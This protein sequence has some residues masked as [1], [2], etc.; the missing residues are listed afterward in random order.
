[1]RGLRSLSTPAKYCAAVAAVIAAS[2]IRWGLDPV[3]GNRY[4]YLLQYITVLLAAR[5]L[6]FGPS[7]VSLVVATLP[8]LYLIAGSSHPERLASPGFWASL[9]AAYAFT[10]F[11]IWLIDRQTRMGA[12][13]ESSTPLADPRLEELKQ[14]VTHREREERLSAQFRAIV[15][16][17]DDAV[18]SKDLSGII[19][20]WNFGAEEIFG[21]TAD[22]MI[23]RPI[24]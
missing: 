15:E 3:L 24:S 20:S 13:V 2:L 7:F 16:S 22:E 4:R 14:E 1:M 5:Y 17:S 10:A 6:G 21:Y 8:A 19:Q 9:A 12:A 23:G 18:L 11:L